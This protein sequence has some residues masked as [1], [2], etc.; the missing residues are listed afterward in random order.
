MNWDPF[1]KFWAPA[2]G[3]AWIRYVYYN[4]ET[5]RGTGYC[6]IYFRRGYDSSTNRAIGYVLAYGESTR[7]DGTA[8]R[9][10]GNVPNQGRWRVIYDHRVDRRD[11]HGYHVGVIS[12]YPI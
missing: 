9:W 8:T 4:R 10:E 6:H 3:E 2:Y 5:A 12:A 7:V 11:P 1:H